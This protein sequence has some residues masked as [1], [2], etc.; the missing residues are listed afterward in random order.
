M[1]AGRNTGRLKDWHV[2]K[3]AERLADLIDMHTIG[4]LF[5]KIV[6]R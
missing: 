5:L 3:Q 1:H 2:G 6:H 4:M